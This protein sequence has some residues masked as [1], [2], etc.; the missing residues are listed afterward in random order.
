MSGANIFMI[1]A[2]AAG[3]NVT[4]SPRTGV[5]EKQPN[6]GGAS[7]TLLDGSGISNN[8]MTANIRCMF[9]Q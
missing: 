2:N 1:Y 9:S 4:L 3:N 7:V 6:V 8:V 5:G